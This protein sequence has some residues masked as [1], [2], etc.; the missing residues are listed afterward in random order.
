MG[1]YDS[2]FNR[3]FDSDVIPE[4]LR[5]MNEEAGYFSA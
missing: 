1:P 4:S 5:R 3:F 2:T